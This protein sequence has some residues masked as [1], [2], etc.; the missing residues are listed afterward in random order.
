MKDFEARIRQH[1]EERGWNTLRPSDIAK[2]IMIEGAELLELFQWDNKSPDEVR[3]DEEKMAAIRNELAD[4]MAYCF[5][6]ASVLDIDVAPMLDEQLRKVQ[7]KYPAHLFNK[8]TQTDNPGT[9][10]IYTQVKGQYL[11]KD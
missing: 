6:M 10:A 3:A 1:L 4:V 11:G 9:E 2:S 8:D 7:E 5:T